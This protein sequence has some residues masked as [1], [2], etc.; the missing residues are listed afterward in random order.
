M[1]LR[2]LKIFHSVAQTKNLSQTAKALGYVQSNV[3]ARI[4][5]L[6][7]E[8]QTQLLYRTPKGAYL[9]PAGSRLLEYAQQFLQLEQEVHQYV[10]NRT[11]IEGSITIGS[12]ES[13][14]STYLPGIL[15]QL[16]KQ[17]PKL[18]INLE[19]SETKHLIQKTV[20]YQLDGAFIAGEYDRPEMHVVPMVEEQLM[21]VTKRTTSPI[22][23]LQ[24]EKSAL[25][26]VLKDGCV[27]RKKLLEWLT[28]NEY[29]SW[30]IME[31]PSLDT[32]IELTKAGMGVSLLSESYLNRRNID[33]NLTLYPLEAPYH[34]AETKFIF[35]KD[36]LQKRALDKVS[37]VLPF[38]T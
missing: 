38:C 26:L 35:R 34:M 17:Y 5:R 7:E 31:C 1:E 9:T 29:H 37:A 6:E 32:I 4:Q 22:D 33:Q 20:N 19:I 21:L 2:D 27:Y 12:I 10:S 15:Q 30:N 24:T 16:M 14:A 8:F 13:A 36:N 3:T 28:I 25:L 18:H 23:M 11:D